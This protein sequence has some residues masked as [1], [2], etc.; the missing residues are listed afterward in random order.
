[1]CADFFTEVDLVCD[2]LHRVLH[3]RFAH[4][5]FGDTDAAALQRMVSP[6]GGKQQ[7]LVTMGFP[8][9]AEQVQGGRRQRQVA[10]FGTFAVMEK[11]LTPERATRSDP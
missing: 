1:M 9:L 6:E 10:I 4:R 3:S 11:N 5:G 2:Q 7:S 8:V